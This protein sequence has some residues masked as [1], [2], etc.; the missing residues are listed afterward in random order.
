MIDPTWRDINRLFVLSIKNG[1][2][3]CARNCF[4]KYYMP[5]VEIKDFNALDGN[6]PFFDQPLKK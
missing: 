2:N 5:L 6:E 4:N 1:D 3:D